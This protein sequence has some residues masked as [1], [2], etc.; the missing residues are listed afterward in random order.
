[1]SSSFSLNSLGWLVLKA[2][3]KSKKVMCTVVLGLFTVQNMP[4]AVDR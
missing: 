3:E 2:Q 1:M 4:Y